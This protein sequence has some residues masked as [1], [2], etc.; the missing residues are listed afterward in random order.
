MSER[1]QYLIDT[2]DLKPHPE[3]GYFKE[4]YRSD[5]MVSSGRHGGR[6]SALTSIYFMLTEG[7][8][9]SFHKVN[10]DEAWHFYEGAPLELMWLDDSFD[11]LNSA[12][13]GPVDKESQPTAIIPTGFWQAAYTTGEFTLVGCSV[14]PGFEFADFSMLNEDQQQTEKLIKNYPELSIYI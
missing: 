3:G 14:G 10:S 11:R 12:V 9:S 1:A 5:Q 2:L 13:L 8:H 7:Q 4:I 6:R